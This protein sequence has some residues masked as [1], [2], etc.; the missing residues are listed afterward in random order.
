MPM[1]ADRELKVLLI[2]DEEQIA[3]AIGDYFERLNIAYN[4]VGCLK[5]GIHHLESGLFDVV[6][7]DLNLPDG[8]GINVIRRA[9]EIDF[10]GNII[11]L[12][13]LNSEFEIIGGLNAGS[14]DYIVKPFSM[15]ELVARIKNLRKNYISIRNNILICGE[16][17]IDTKE[18]RVSLNNNA[19]Q[20]TRSEFDL[21]K[22]FIDN[23]NMVL[24]HA[25]IG[26][27]LHKRTNAVENNTEF[28]YSHVKNLKNKISMFTNKE[29]IVTVY[30]IGYKFKLS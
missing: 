13:S 19:I 20:L 6:I 7:L 1:L 17:E 10:K 3:K 11:I 8:H 23:P 9:N 15:A 26:R 30:G 2:E 22:F 16:I 4:A 14:D 18:M 21:L 5:D 29:Y 27:H 24:T 28:V 25:I 12:S